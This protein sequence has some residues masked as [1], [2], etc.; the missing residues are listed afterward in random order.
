MDFDRFEIL[1]F[2]CYGTLV[3]WEA[4]ILA[5]IRPVLRAHALTL[6]D[7]AVL[8]LYAEIE[9]SVQAAEFLPYAEVLR[10]VMDGMGERLRF[11]PT[12]HERNALV[13]SI[14]DWPAFPDTPAALALLKRRYKLYV[15]SN[16]DNDL[17]ARTAP[18]LGVT[19]D[20]VITA[21]QVRSYKPAPGHFK[22]LLQQTGAAKEQVLHVAQ[23]LFHDIVP[24]RQLGFATVW[25][26][27]R[28]SGG[29][30]TPPAEASPD[31]VVADL[32]ELARLVAMGLAP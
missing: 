8:A 15:L 28:A 2:D 18:H 26:Q 19:L 6:S 1:T 17:F 25:V 21:Q 3:D 20:G 27:R 23:S 11:R 24:A 4:G 5:A 32:A 7:D 16:V 14:G 13:D 29:G 10:R 31:L 30:A 12:P 9:P 22:A